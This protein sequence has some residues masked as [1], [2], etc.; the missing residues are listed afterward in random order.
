M[1]LCTSVGN[2]AHHQKLWLN[3]NYM[4]KKERTEE[5]QSIHYHKLFLKEARVRIFYASATEG[6]GGIIFPGCPSVRPDVRPDYSFTR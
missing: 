5:G 4:R 2:V 6:A 1:L 3:F